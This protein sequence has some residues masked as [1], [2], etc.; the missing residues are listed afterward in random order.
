MGQFNQQTSRVPVFGQIQQL[1]LAIPV[2]LS[3]HGLF[4][5]GQ[6]GGQTWQ[7]IALM[8]LG[9]SGLISFLTRANGSLLQ[10]IRL[11][12]MVIL[13]WILMYSTGGTRSFFLIWYFLIAPAYVL[14]LPRTQ[15]LILPLTLSAIY[16]ILIPLSPIGIPL[17]VSISRA[18]LF[19][20]VSYLVRALAS[21]TQLYA[22]QLEQTIER[23]ELALE[24]GK[25]E[26]QDFEALTAETIQDFAKIAIKE[27]R[28]LLEQ[29][30]T[31]IMRG[32]SPQSVEFRTG[33]AEHPEW[34]SLHLKNTNHNGQTTIT[35]ITQDISIS[36]N[37]EQDRILYAVQK[38]RSET[39][40][41]IVQGLSHDLKTPL[42]VIGTS[43]YLLE[44]NDDNPG[45][46]KRIETIRKQ[47]NHLNNSIQDI[48][49]I[50]SLHKITGVTMHRLDINKVVA[51]IHDDFSTLAGGESKEM[52][53]KLDSTLPLCVGNRLQLY[54]MLANLVQNAIN[55]TESGGTIHIGT[56]KNDSFIIIEIRDSGIGI[57]PEHHEKIFEQFYRTDPARSTHTGGSGLGLSIVKRILDLHHGH[58]EVKSEAG[59]G[60]TFQVFLPELPRV[61]D[62]SN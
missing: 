36:K 24:A 56:T 8:V 32:K 17:S 5:L 9:I 60:A 38:E 45:N 18:V 44:K 20:F 15:A 50:A 62:T 1:E 7:F 16:L 40:T 58:I 12:F 47:I 25:L 54:R 26:I 49:T 37:A 11:I 59:H 41:D 48:L 10:L 42:T 43:L 3:L 23:L 6:V 13:C 29:A 21:S 31:N 53:C 35:A 14:I 52:T 33:D 30:L 2:I 22:R 28:E 57:A 55:Y 4:V 39:V 34:L 61:G 46:A 27:D 19:V 51:E